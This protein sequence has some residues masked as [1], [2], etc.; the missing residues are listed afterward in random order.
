MTK[1]IQEMS[2]IPEEETNKTKQKDNQ[3]HNN[4]KIHA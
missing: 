2:C 4:N 1:S 3:N